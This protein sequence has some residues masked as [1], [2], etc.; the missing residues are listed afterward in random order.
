MHLV[1]LF[2]EIINLLLQCLLLIELLIILLLLG[3]RIGGNLRHLDIFIDNLLQHLR[4]NGK[5]ILLQDMVP[6]FV[7]N[8]KPGRQNT[9]DLLNRLMAFNH[10]RHDLPCMETSY[11][12]LQFFLNFIQLSSGFFLIQILHIIKRVRL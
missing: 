3:S 8:A 1:Q 12:I 9:A 10:A 5:S 6:L 7:V 2:L 11:Q 4:T